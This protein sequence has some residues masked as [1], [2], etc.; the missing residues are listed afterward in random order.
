M[1]A[2]FCIVIPTTC[3]AL[4]IE[5]AFGGGVAERANSPSIDRLVPE[6]GYVPHNIT[7]ISHRANLL[8]NNGTLEEILMVIDWMKSKIS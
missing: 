1:E 8:K 7:I 5:L 4:G 2:I 3:P 6:L